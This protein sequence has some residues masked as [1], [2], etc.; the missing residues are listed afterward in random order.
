[1][2]EYLQT[3]QVILLF[4]IIALGLIIGRIKLWGF[5]FESSAILFVAMAFGHYGF[6]LDSDFMTLGLIFFI[7][8]IGLQAGPSIFNISR[9]QGFQLNLIVLFLLITGALTTYLTA[10]FFNLDMDIAVG[11]FAG[12]FTST[13]DHFLT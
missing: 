11:L 8:S 3:H 4:L 5:S 10:V 7:Y 1:M 6:T 9:K 13:P 2:F 12:A